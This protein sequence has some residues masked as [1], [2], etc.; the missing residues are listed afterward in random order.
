MWKRVNN[1]NGLLSYKYIQLDCTIPPSG[2]QTQNLVCELVTS[3]NIQLYMELNRL[4]Y[5]LQFTGSLPCLAMLSANTKF[6][7]LNIHIYAYM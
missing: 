7:Y 4:V 6:I 3:S 2:E 5:L 1:D